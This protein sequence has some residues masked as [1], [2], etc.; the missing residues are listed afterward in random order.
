[1]SILLKFIINLLDAVLLLQTSVLFISNPV[2]RFLGRF[3][4]L[5][6]VLSQIANYNLRLKWRPP[7]QPRIG[8]YKTELNHD[9]PQ[10]VTINRRSVADFHINPRP[11]KAICR[12]VSGCLRLLPI[13]TD[14]PCFVV[15]SNFSHYSGCHPKHLSPF[16]QLYQLPNK[17]N[18]CN[19]CVRNSGSVDD[20]VNL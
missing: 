16:V 4:R 14:K 20:I 7:R 1:M 9:G 3:L 15:T 5:P 10:K 12:S 11:L 19:V 6:V 17:L 13:T 2:W 18:S 8:A